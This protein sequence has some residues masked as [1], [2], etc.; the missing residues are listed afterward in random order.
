MICEF[1]TNFCEKPWGILVCGAG[2]IP[3]Y[4][5]IEAC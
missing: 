5:E 4:R 2:K 3:I 1:S